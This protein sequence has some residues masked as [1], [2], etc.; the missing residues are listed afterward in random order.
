MTLIRWIAL[1]VFWTTWARCTCISTCKWHCFVK[2]G[3]RLSEN[4]KALDWEPDSTRHQTSLFKISWLFLDR[5]IIVYNKQRNNIAHMQCY[6][7]TCKNWCSKFTHLC[8]SSQFLFLDSLICSSWEVQFVLEGSSS[9]GKKWHRFNFY[10]Y[11]YIKQASHTRTV[12]NQ[13]LEYAFF[14]HF[15]F[16]T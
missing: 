3:K 12:L 4:S 16:H 10:E 8:F 6:S 9:K 11:M 13:H 5:E 1:S 7:C 14:I 15:F 2:Q